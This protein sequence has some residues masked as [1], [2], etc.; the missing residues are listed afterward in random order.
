MYIKLRNGN[1]EKYSIEQLR[2]DNPN[3]SFPK[4]PS[5]ALLAEWNIYPFVVVEQPTHDYL[6]QTVTEAALTETNGIWT[7]GWIITNLP[8]ERAENNIR[9]QRNNLLSQTDWMALSDN[10]MSLEWSAYRQALRDITTQEGFPES[11]SWPV[12]PE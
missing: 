2:C 4:V 1:P 11:V 9:S 10:T 12:K 6:T 8:V 3:T 7:Q 5:D